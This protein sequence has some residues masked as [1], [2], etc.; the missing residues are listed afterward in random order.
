MYMTNLIKLKN[1]LFHKIDV[2]WFITLLKVLNTVI[3]I[4]LWITER[5]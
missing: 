1:I 2:V 4:W 5:I 3:E